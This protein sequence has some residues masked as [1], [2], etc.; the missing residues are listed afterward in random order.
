MAILAAT[1]QSLWI[2]S[3]AK[4][5]MAYLCLWSTTAIL[6]I[7]LT[8]AQLLTRAPGATALA[9]SDDA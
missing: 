4:H 7:V 6:A 8:G 2:S 1:A 9:L 5:L 3:P